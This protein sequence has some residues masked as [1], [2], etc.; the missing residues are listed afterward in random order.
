M[1][2]PPPVL[3]PAGAALELRRPS[4]WQDA[5]DVGLKQTHIDV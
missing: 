5:P 2:W 4:G 1:Q 3:V